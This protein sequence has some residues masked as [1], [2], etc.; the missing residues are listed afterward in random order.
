LRSEWKYDKKWGWEDWSYLG[1]RR[2]RDE[3]WEDFVEEEVEW[4]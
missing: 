2:W 1:H 4:G 3:E